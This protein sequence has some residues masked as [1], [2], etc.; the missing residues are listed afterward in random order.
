M[1]EMS[2]D[3]V[4]E[5]VD[6]INPMI[7]GAGWELALVKKGE[8][9]SSEEI[10]GGEESLL[11]KERAHKEELEKF[12]QTKADIEAREIALE[13]QEK[14]FDAIK[15]KLMAASAEL[16]QKKADLFKEAEK[17]ASGLYQDRLTAVESEAKK[18]IESAQASS[19]KTRA[20]AEIGAQ[21]IREEAY[22]AA[23]QIRKE[24]G[25]EKDRIIKQADG[26]ARKKMEAAES[27][28]ASLKKQIEKL[29]AEK[30]ELSGKNTELMSRNE[31][32][33]QDNA[34]LLSEKNSQKDEFNRTAASYKST[35]DLYKSLNDLLNLHNKD[36]KTF[37]DEIN[38]LNAREQELNQ[39]EDD[40][41]K[42][43]QRLSFDERRN[44]NKADALDTREGDIETEVNNR[45]QR[46]CADKDAEIES[47]QKQAQ[48]LREALATKSS[49]V[50]SFDDLKAE[51]GGKNPAEVLLDYQRVQQELQLAV[52]KVG[53]TP[54]YVLKKTA[55]ELKERED[56]LKDRENKLEQEKRDFANRHDDYARLQTQCNDL[57][58][59]VDDCRRE[60]KMLEERVKQL[61]SLYENSQEREDRIAAINK[62]FVVDAVRSQNTEGISEI[63]WLN[64]IEENIEKSGLHFPRR[65][66]DAF[67]TALKTSEMSPL[68]VLAGVSGTG[69][70]ELPRLYSRFGGINFLSVPVQPNW[71]CQEAM[72]GYYNS[73]ENCFEPTDMLRVLAQSQRDADK[74]NGLNDYMTMIL[75]D[76]MNLANVELYFAEFLSKLETRRGLSE[77]DPNFPNIGVK[78][79]SQM[80]NFSLHLGRN[81]LWTGTMNNDETTK[82]LSDKVIDR[83]I[84]INFP[85]P[86]KLIRSRIKNK[87]EEPADL[88][89]KS[90]WSLWVD[91][92]YRFDEDQ[93]GEYKDRVERINEQL[94]R[95]GRA[96]GHRVWQSIENYMSL[97]PGVVAAQSDYERHQA[98]E[99][100]FEDQ[101]VQKV[102][103]KLR[104]LE[105]RGLQKDVLEAIKK[106]LPETLHKDFENAMEQN[107]GQFI[108]TTSGYLL[109][110]DGSKDD[111]ESESSAVDGASREEPTRSESVDPIVKECV[112]LI[113]KGECKRDKVQIKNIL[114]DRGAY[115]PDRLKLVL[116]MTKK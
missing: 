7:D 38:G 115:S 73:I 21:K 102:M 71:D 12:L 8:K 54:S 91:C 98:M 64:G 88:L 9:T 33:A 105:T 14:A 51:L 50:A 81:V 42:R 11:Q 99:R 113:K 15:E 37:I 3:K 60:K 55:E 84:V 107:Y 69:K 82:T 13:S 100:A 46:L 86:K 31:A 49:I 66:I 89:P 77:N 25:A 83:G 61:H 63:S 78:V 45:W 1:A 30:A 57:S 109:R 75:L 24:A 40:L 28:T 47:L 110:E 72:L 68:T 65:I 39:R 35:M 16:A 76:E 111:K 101:L 26:D 112:Q 41:N 93:I 32:L 2:L 23:E 34:A 94:G 106:E 87:L 59:E 108:W 48:T 80:E 74:E 96:L 22:A 19:E 27:D 116:D 85:R 4:K 43:N 36:V 52:Q 29:I 20:E 62:A 70:S 44:A 67:H 90:V 18:I 5:F 95:G 114:E 17:L 10:D 92:A 104:G 97:Y 53:E 58:Q 56:F 103:P 6:Q 79:G